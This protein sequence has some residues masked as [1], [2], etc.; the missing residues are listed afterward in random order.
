MSGNPGA[1]QKPSLPEEIDLLVT[2]WTEINNATYVMYIT[3]F[4]K[5]N[6]FQY[7]YNVKKTIKD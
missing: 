4:I 5:T 1:E 7:E 6:K 2:W 3:E